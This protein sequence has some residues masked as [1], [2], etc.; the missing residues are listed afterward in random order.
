MLQTKR[1]LW[2]AWIDRTVDVDD[3]TPLFATDAAD[4]PTSPDDFGDLR[5]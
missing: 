5:T 3:P 1:T 2:E 4:D